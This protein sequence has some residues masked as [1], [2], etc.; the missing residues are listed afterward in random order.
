LLYLPRKLTEPSSELSASWR[1]GGRNDQE[2]SGV[3]LREVSTQQKTITL[4]TYNFYHLEVV[5][6]GLGALHPCQPCR[7]KS[8][9]TVYPGMAEMG[10]DV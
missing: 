8:P 3:H 9:Q 10:R 4:S 1:P 6:P 5:S 7:F 2:K